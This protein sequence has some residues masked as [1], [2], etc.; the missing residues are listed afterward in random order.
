MRGLLLAFSLHVG[1]AP[2]G[3]VADSWFSR[4]KAQH[5][6]MSAFIQS[7]GYGVL[8]GAGLRHG[9]ALGGASVTTAAIG[10]GKELHDRDV[11]GDF[12][13]RDLTWDAAGAG[14]MSLLLAHTAR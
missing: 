2:Q 1:P 3:G 9:A 4:D 6:L 12:S 10:V 11:K 13:A 5:F 14:S 7:A 8:R